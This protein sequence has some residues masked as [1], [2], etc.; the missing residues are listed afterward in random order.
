[1]KSFLF[2]ITD[3]DIRTDG[4]F[5]YDGETREVLKYPSLYDLLD[6]QGFHDYCPEEEHKYARIIRAIEKDGFFVC[7]DDYGYWHEP[8]ARNM[9][10]NP[11]IHFVISELTDAEIKILEDIEAG[12]LLDEKKKWDKFIADSKMGN[13]ELIELLRNGYMFP[14]KIEG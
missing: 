11:A 8:E 1:M 9:I 2:I 5:S 10:Y 3:I 6:D 4:S 7:H 14:T 13:S 12:K